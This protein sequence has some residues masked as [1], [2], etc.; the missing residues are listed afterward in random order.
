MGD[1]CKVMEKSVDKKQEAVIEITFDKLSYVKD[2]LEDLEK[3][4][5]G[6]CCSSTEDLIKGIIKIFG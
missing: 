2:T 4:L 5:K 1:Y 3:I 6:D